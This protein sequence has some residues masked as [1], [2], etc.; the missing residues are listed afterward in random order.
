MM[1]LFWLFVNV[2]QWHPWNTRKPY[3]WFWLKCYERLKRS[4]PNWMKFSKT[5]SLELRSTPLFIVPRTKSNY[6]YKK[7]LQRF[8]VFNSIFWHINYWFIF[9]WSLTL[10][11][12]LCQVKIKLN[13]SKFY[14]LIIDR[15]I[16]TIVIFFSKEFGHFVEH[17]KAQFTLEQSILI[18]MNGFNG[19]E[20][21]DFAS[22][23]S[24]SKDFDSIVIFI[25]T[26]N[27]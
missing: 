6:K 9:H 12:N 8:L 15:F 21:A 24:I 10:D 22:N 16:G 17:C 5:T 2:Q 18:A 1:F 20:K 3:P 4:H 14:S 13:F 7:I 11:N 26:S 19:L 25:K 23:E 27:P